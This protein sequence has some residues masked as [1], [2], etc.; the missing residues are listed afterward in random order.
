[1]LVQTESQKKIH[2]STK[3][4]HAVLATTF[5]KLKSTFAHFLTFCSSSIFNKSFLK[6]LEMGRELRKKIIFYKI[7]TYS[8]VQP[9]KKKFCET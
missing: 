1:M 2:K 3:I 5:E 8:S 9:P 4:C 7:Y 6:L